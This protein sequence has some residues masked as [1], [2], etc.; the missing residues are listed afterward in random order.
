MMYG[1]WKLAIL[2]DGVHMMSDT[3][4]EELHQ[5]AQGMGLKRKWFQ[6]KNPRHLHYD[7]TTPNAVARALRRGA[8]QVTSLELVRACVPGF[9]R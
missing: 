7:L 6:C 3:S 5:F 1:M 9:K 4:V 2:T 8:K